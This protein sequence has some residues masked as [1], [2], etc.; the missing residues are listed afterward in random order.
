METLASFGRQGWIRAFD[1]HFVSTFDYH[2]LNGRKSAQTALILLS[3]VW[4]NQVFRGS[5]APPVSL[6]GLAFPNNT[7]VAAGKKRTVTVHITRK[8][9]SS[10]R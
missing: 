1:P 2:Y 9:E 5:T 6:F 7:D 10:E 8:R 3:I 4:H